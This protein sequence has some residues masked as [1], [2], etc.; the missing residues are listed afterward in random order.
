MLVSE[1]Q[2]QTGRLKS[3]YITLSTL[4][5][6]LIGCSH[7]YHLE[8][9]YQ[10]REVCLNSLNPTTATDLLKSGTLKQTHL[11]E[12]FIIIF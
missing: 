6:R 1:F 5:A 11:K 8:V 3:V 10:F 2:E 9:R 4:Q 7:L 12:A